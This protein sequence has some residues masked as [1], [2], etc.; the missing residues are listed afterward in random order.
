MVLLLAAPAILAALFARWMHRRWAN[1]ATVFLG[2]L[3]VQLALYWLMIGPEGYAEPSE[4]TLLASG[5]GLFGFAAG[6][7]LAMLIMLP[8]AQPWLGTPQRFL[9][10]PRRRAKRLL[11]VA[12]ACTLVALVWHAAVGVENIGAG[13]TGVAVLDL[14][15]VYLANLDSFSLA[16]HVAIVAQFLLLYLYLHGHRPRLTMSLFLLVSIGC[17]VWKVERSAIMMAGYSALVALEMRQGRPLSM[18]W[19]VGAVCVAMGVFMLTAMVRDGWES[20]GEVLALLA[21]Y[22]AKNVQN[23]NAFVID[24]PING[25]P[26]LILGKYATVFGVPPADIGIGVDEYFNTY[27]YLRP[28]YLFGGLWGCLAFGVALGI[29]SALLYLWSLRRPLVA[30]V[31]C[32]ASFALFLSFFDYAFS[33]TNWAYYAI[34][35]LALSAVRFRLVGRAPAYGTPQ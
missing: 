6:Y 34:V 11:R 15:S 5:G 14:R 28:V 13:D 1:P 16:P 3:G 23:F 4:R 2:I 26:E 35:G 10:L 27:S 17:A 19:M 22:F 18:R 7:L 20:A 8:I 24:Q 12:L 33:W 29:G 21:D 32:F 31:Y 30:V 25:S 9:T